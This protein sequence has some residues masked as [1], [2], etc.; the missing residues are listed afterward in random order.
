MDSLGS[1]DVGPP[2]T[3]AAAAAKNTGYMHQYGR[4]DLYQTRGRGLGDDRGVEVYV[5]DDETRV[6]H[7]VA[8]WYH[9]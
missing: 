2:S 8:G 7:R 3:E 5:V 1:L 4:G 6:V 9:R